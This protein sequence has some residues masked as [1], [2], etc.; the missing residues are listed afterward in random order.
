MRNINRMYSIGYCYQSE[1]GI[2]KDNH[3]AF[4]YYKKSTD[5]S[6]ANRMS[7]VSN[8]YSKGFNELYDLE[9]CI[10]NSANKKKIVVF[11]FDSLKDEYSKAKELLLLGYSHDLYKASIQV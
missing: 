10:R 1:F 2:E 7:I 11:N 6:S 3:K 9:S 5:A 8:C 4:K